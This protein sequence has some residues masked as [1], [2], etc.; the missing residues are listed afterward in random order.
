[1]AGMDEGSEEGWWIVRVEEGKDGWDPDVEWRFS[2]GERHV[3]VI[4]RICS[5]DTT[6][7]LI[8]SGCVVMFPNNR[9]VLHCSLPQATEITTSTACEKLYK[10]VFTSTNGDYGNGSPIRNAFPGLR[11]RMGRTKRRR[12]VRCGEARLRQIRVAGSNSRLSRRS[13]S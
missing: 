3:R 11:L 13:K 1:V 2:S 5:W 10:S 7:D 6:I 4:L 12:S 9:G 8:F